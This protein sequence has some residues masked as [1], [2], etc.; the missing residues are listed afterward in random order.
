MFKGWL[1]AKQMV[2]FSELQ[3]IRFVLIAFD[4]YELNMYRAIYVISQPNLC[5]PGDVFAYLLFAKWTPN[6][7]FRDAQ[8]MLR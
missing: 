1:F 3:M 6:P 8:L 2:A 7:K 5:F 4:Y